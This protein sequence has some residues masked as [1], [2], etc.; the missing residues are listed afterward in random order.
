MAGVGAGAP[1]GRAQTPGFASSGILFSNTAVASVRVTEDLFASRNTIMG[2]VLSGACGEYG[3]NGVAGIGIFLEDGTRVVTDDKGRYHFEGVRSGTHVVQVDLETVPEMYEIVACDEDTR[4][5]GRPW[6]RFTDLAGGTLWRVDFYLVPRA[7]EEGKAVLVLKTVTEPERV[8]FSANMR[9]ERVPLQNVRFQVTL[10]QGVE[11]EP[12]TARLEGQPVGDPEEDGNIL[13]WNIGDV[14]GAWEKGITFETSIRE[15]WDWLRDTSRNPTDTGD[16]YGT[17]RNVKGRMNEV[18]S[19]ASVT[20]DTPVRQN[21]STPE[22]KNVLLKVAQRDETVTRKFVFRPH[23][24]TFEARLT[25]EDR[26]ALDIIAGQ[27]DPAEIAEVQVTGHTDNVPISRRGKRI[28]ADNHELS[29]VRAR[30]VARYLRDVWDLPSDLFNI[31]GRGADEPVAPNE[32]T[33]GRTLN[34]R[35][36]VNVITTTVQ[37]VTVLKPIHDQN[38]TEIVIEGLRPGAAPVYPVPEPDPGMR[39]FTDSTKDLAW[40]ET[41]NG[42]LRWVL[43]EPGFLPH[44]PSLKIAV[45]HPPQQKIRILLDGEA[46][47]PLHFDSTSRNTL[48]TAALSFWRG[49]DILE[50][51]NRLTAV[52]LDSGGNEI[53]RIKQV[54]HYSGSPVHMEFR[55]DLSRLVADGIQPPVVAVRLTDKDGFPARQGIVGQY[56]V[57]SPFRTLQQ[58]RAGTTEAL[59]DR[60]GGYS[61]Y[62]VKGDGIAYLELEPTTQS[63]EAVLMVRL[64]GEDQEIPVWLNAHRE[65]WILVGLAE[66]TVGYRVAKGNMESLEDSGAEEDLY[67]EGRLAFFARGRIK[68][69]Y[70][71]TMSYDTNGPHGAAGEG[72]H[73]T[74]DPD[75]YYTLYGDTAQQDYEAPTSGKLY[76]KIEKDSFFALFGD[77]R[78]GMTVTE[79]SRYDR[80]I[81]GL[82]AQRKGQK[83][84]Y[85]L[86]A[87]GSEQGFVKDEIPGDGTSGVYRL[88][89]GDVVVNSESVT[90]EV[91]DRFQSHV[92][93]TETSMTRHVDYSIDYDEGTLFFKSPVPQRDAGFNPVLIVVDYETQDPDATGV[94]YGARGEAVLPDGRSRVGLSVI[95]EDRGQG[96]GDLVGLDAEV[97]L[98]EK[99]TVKAEA[100]AS[101]SDLSGTE[102]DGSAYILEIGHDS[103]NL[104]GKAYIRQQ[105]DEFGLGHQKASEGGMRKV[106]AE[107]IYYL[108]DSWSL[109]AEVSAQE[110]LETGE[111]R[112]VE[113]LGVVRDAGR[114]QYSASVRKATD[115]DGGGIEERSRQVTAGVDWNSA[116]ERW[117]LR[118]SHEQ[119]LGDNGNTAYPTRTLL[120]SDY[121]L[122]DTVSLYA[123]QE[124]TDGD[125]TSVSSSRAGL[126]ATPWEGGT[127]S[128]TI[129]RQHDEN[130]DRVYAT[131]GLN[132]TWQV[133][134]RWQVSAG[135]EGASVIDENTTEPINP[136]TEPVSNE[137]DYSAVSLG[138]GYGAGNWE[139]DV[140]L[141]IRDA[142][143]SDKWGLVAGVFGE[144][145]EGVGLS[146]NLKHFRIEDSGGIRTTETDMRLGL[147]YRPLD[148]YWTFLEKLEYIVDEESGS[149]LDYRT[150]KMVNNFNA[151]YRPHD[152][153]QISFQ[154]GSKYVKDI[155]DGQIFDGF[156]HLLGTQGRYDL[157]GRWDIGAWTSILA[158]V[159]AGTTE[160]GLGASLGYG[161][162]ENIWLS[163]GYN[164]LGF[165]D[166]DFSQGDFTA[167]GPFVKFRLKFDQEDLKSIL[168]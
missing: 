148:R 94:T 83:Y 87:S 57:Q 86:F 64:Q 35:V 77:T 37:K 81:T 47:N 91:R 3:P 151:N 104:E 93:L 53:G 21:I 100:A 134:E 84:S 48:G 113:E 98:S 76:L 111:D 127:A 162:M 79:L 30:S 164:L 59:A 13:T 160:Y 22:V 55:P 163:F 121:R 29:R 139:A 65:D 136:E 168:R 28:F 167:Q 88:S 36:E 90:I 116:D 69:E 80:A 45:V 119:S 155:I 126:K 146:T 82:R 140:R 33:R 7:P 41:D 14:P 103:A 137:E 128:T 38:V 105:D 143:S 89:A 157:T 161:L 159:E 152:D 73:G 99:V 125:E 67:T 141:E 19:S 4:Q 70:L 122:S 18:M 75:T 63:G 120:G 85:N 46:I 147:V 142:D 8:I 43:P 61:T 49:V 54:V 16:G 66:G 10:P 124:F 117:N 123:E 78:T 25:P 158:A 156:T 74:I 138:A 32:T 17:F 96:E 114:L 44:I 130:G 153:L 56:Y 133:S 27:F 68:G 24:A 20:F 12:G 26:E 165:E 97:S 95:H 42:T 15:D 166:S 1:P 149:A 135:F 145:V 102:F 23:F 2:R 72:H 6:S 50:G 39:A 132:Q 51:D 11:F 92:V 62:S 131:T 154:L 110:N 34:R 60:R 5:A 115:T 106:G 107:G 58:A 52:A 144:P 71:L 118:A 101:S 109:T 108:T 40:L 9:G 31:E 150:W 129:D 112:T